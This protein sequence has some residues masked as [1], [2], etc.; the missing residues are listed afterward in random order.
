[1]AELLVDAEAAA[2]AIAHDAG[3]EARSYAS[4]KRR[5]T[6]R[7][8]SQRLQ[9]VLRLRQE[10][11]NQANAFERGTEILVAALVDAT[12]TLTQA[13]Y[14]MPGEGAGATGELTLK[15]SERRRISVTL[16]GEMDESD[17]MIAAE[18]SGEDRALGP[19]REVDPTRA[20]PSRLARLWLWRPRWWRRG[21]PSMAG[22]IRPERVPYDVPQPVAPDVPSGVQDADHARA[23]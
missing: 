19:N 23:A 18:A 7:L 12:R 20:A 14:E 5:E 22:S 10:V 4:S 8:L 17:T 2:D 16:S 1:M 11:S 3:V 15:L 9:D 21:A 6:E 13:V